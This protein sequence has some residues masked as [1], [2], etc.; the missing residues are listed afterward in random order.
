MVIDTSILLAIFFNEAYSQW[1]A[2]QLNTH[3]DKLCM[4]TVNLTETLIQL[5]DR[6]PKQFFRT[7]AK[8]TLKQHPF[9]SARYISSTNRR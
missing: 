1:A 5:Q 7:E 2:N 4:S 6:Q 3:T 8:L 9:Y